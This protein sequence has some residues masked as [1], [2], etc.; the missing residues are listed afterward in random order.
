MTSAT[1][2]TEASKFERMPKVSVILTVK[3]EEKTIGHAIKYWLRRQ[4][5][6]R[7]LNVLSEGGKA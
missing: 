1:C 4:I 7:Q 5:H 2:N 6:M 3:N